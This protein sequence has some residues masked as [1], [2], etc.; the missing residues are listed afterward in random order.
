MK[1]LVTGATGFLGKALVAR[2]L[3]DGGLGP[4]HPPLSRLILL[5]RS[6]GE[7]PQD[8]RLR[9]VRGDIGSPQARA[10]AL[11]DGVDCVFH[12]AGAL[13]AQTEPN[14][15]LGRDVNLTASIELCEEL[16]R[17]DLRPRFLF[18]STI[19]VYG[20]GLPDPVTDD[21]PARPN[22]TYGAHK[23]MVEYYLADLARRGFLD[24][25]SVRIP[26]TLPRP[27]L[28]DRTFSPAFGSNLIH[29]MSAGE[30]FHSPVS[31][32]ATLWAVSRRWTID[33]LIRSA[34]V[35]A[36]GLPRHRVWQLPALVVT[37]GELA[38]ALADRFGADRLTRVQ[39]DPIPELESALGTL[40]RLV[41]ATADRLGLRHDGDVATLVENVLDDMARHPL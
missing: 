27:R 12:L 20:P 4:E 37:M 34:A 10:E 9:L 3:A 22:L 36:D 6:F 13:I 30:A 21:T 33:N 11:A 28:P 35:A 8:P 24:A 40:P 19:G 17:R 25:R 26:G 23:L 2:L 31:E 14:F 38:R 39:W 7:P 18:A 15:D 1:I 41:T 16:R 32:K 29:A 5:G